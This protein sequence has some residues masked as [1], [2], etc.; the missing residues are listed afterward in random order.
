MTKFKHEKPFAIIPWKT[1]C[2][3]ILQ[4]DFAI[5]FLQ[6]TICERKSVVRL[7]AHYKKTLILIALPYNGY[8]EPSFGPLTKKEWNFTTAH[9]AILDRNP[10][11]S[12]GYDY[13][14]H[15]G[16]FC[17][18][19][20]TTSKKGGAKLVLCLHSRYIFDWNGPKMDLK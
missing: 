6:L 18:L 1:K 9:S 13:L 15:Q 10:I 5:F 17:R 14:F 3:I 19:V 7:G 12:Q 11:F 20:L 16:I 2:L 4:N 8:S